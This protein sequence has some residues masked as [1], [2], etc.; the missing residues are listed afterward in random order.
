VQLADT[1]RQEAVM[2]PTVMSLDQLDRDIS[3]AYIALRAARASFARSPSEE[4]AR[5]VDEAERAV[6]RLLDERLAA[7][8]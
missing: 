3:A 2:S 1:D 7:Q 8:R 5:R 6:D 4:N